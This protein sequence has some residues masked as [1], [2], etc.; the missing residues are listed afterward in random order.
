MSMLV[1]P[2]FADFAHGLTGVLQFIVAFVGYV[3][4]FAVP[5]G[6]LTVGIHFCLS[7]PLRRRERARLFL[8][9]LETGLARGQSAEQTVMGVAGSHDRT[10]GVRF[11]LL[12]THLENG[13]RLDTALERVPRLLPPPVAAMLRVG[14]RLGDLRRVLPACREWLRERPASVQSAYHYLV[15]L[16]LVFSPVAIFLL[17]NLNVFVWPKLVE[18]FLGT[19]ESAPLP[20]VTRLALNVTRWLVGVQ[21]LFMLGLFLAA[22]VYIG[23]PRV[24]GWLR[25]RAFPLA[26]WLAWRVPWKRKRLVRTFS[27]TLGVLLDGGVPEAEAVRLAADCTANQIAQRRAA[28]VEAALRQGAKLQD[29]VAAFDDAGEFRWRL[30]NACHANDGFLRALSGW[31]EALDAK[32]FQQE[33]AAAHLVTSGLVVFNGVVVALTATA[34]FAALIAVMERAGT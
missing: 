20:A 34:V 16:L 29:A 28:R 15:M 24:A 3:L 1:Q 33:E 31:H 9:L 26:D 6:A 21:V 12:A 11:H 10:L 32:S 8:D 4:L 2:L 19:G 7:L 27:A 13:L 14:A 25:G 17:I 23:G 5:V 22:F 18:V 30:T